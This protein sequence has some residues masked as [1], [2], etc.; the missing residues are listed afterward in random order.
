ML[1]ESVIVFSKQLIDRFFLEEREAQNLQDFV[2]SHFQAE[3][4]S[5]DGDG[6]IVESCGFE[7]TECILSKAKTNTPR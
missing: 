5:D 1:L 4:L 3:T 6:G 7:E 2:E